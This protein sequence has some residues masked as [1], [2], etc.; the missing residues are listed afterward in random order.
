MA[1]ET[2]TFPLLLGVCHRRQPVSSTPTSVLAF[3]V[4]KGRSQGNI[5][6]HLKGGF[7]IKHPFVNFN[8]FCYF[9]EVY[10]GRDALKLAGV[11]RKKK[12]PRF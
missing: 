11:Q 6:V 9:C 12:H 4:K 1:L 8:I 2:L 7:G 5:D 10:L 3:L